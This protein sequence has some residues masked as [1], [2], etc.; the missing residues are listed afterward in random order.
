MVNSIVNTL[1]IILQYSVIANIPKKEQF[2]LNTLDSL[3]QIYFY[4][5]EVITAVQVGSERQ[6]QLSDGTIRALKWLLLSFPNK[7]NDPVSLKN[8]LEGDKYWTC[9]KEVLGWTIY[10]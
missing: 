7:E 3:T 8:L 6:C 4:M 2:P 5:Y 1:L 9:V 10:T